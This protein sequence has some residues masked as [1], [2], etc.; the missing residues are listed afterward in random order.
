MNDFSGMDSIQL[1]GGEGVD[2]TAS[3]VGPGFV[4]AFS[5]TRRSLLRL[6]ALAG[7][8]SVVPHP[9]NVLNAF[10]TAVSALC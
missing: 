6:N 2:K 7:T 4:S 8:V 10:S 5:R 1:P 3:I 9:P